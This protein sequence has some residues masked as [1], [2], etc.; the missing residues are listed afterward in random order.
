MN[1]QHTVASSWA[2]NTELLPYAH[3]SDAFDAPAF[4]GATPP[5]SEPIPH[6]HSTSLNSTRPPRHSFLSQGPSARCADAFNYEPNRSVTFSPSAWSPDTT[7][8]SPSQPR[9][10]TSPDSASHG[11]YRDLSGVASDYSHQ[12]TRRAAPARMHRRTSSAQPAFF[13][14]SFTTSSRSY[15]PM[16]N[17]G[18]QTS[19][20]SSH[21]VPTEFPPPS[22][23]SQRM[24]SAPSAEDV[25]QFLHD[26]SEMLGPE[27]IK[28]LPTSMPRTGPS[29]LEFSAAPPAASTSRTSRSRQTYNVA[30]V[31][32]NEEEYRQYRQAEDESFESAHRQA[33][34]SRPPSYSARGMAV[35]VPSFQGYEIYRP[36][37]APPSPQ[38]DLS[39]G[40]V[41]YYSPPPASFEAA[42]GQ[43]SSSYSSF[44]YGR[45]RGSSVDAAIPRTFVSTPSVPQ[46]YG[47]ASYPTPAFIPPPSNQPASYPSPYI[48][49]TATM[50]SPRTTAQSAS[51]RKEVKSPRT[52]TAKNKK[53]AAVVSFINFSPSD[54][55]ALLSGV[56]PSGSS[57]K[58]QRNSTEDQSGPDE[59]PSKRK[60]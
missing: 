6:I 28:I 14:S 32:L 25:N 45:R 2:S 1:S 51:P 3:S 21:S 47:Y 40:F 9:H 16:E 38:V 27:T 26:M 43:L 10:A 44:H 19:T 50:S 4:D 18:S 24:Q 8:P 54:S 52:P 59:S 35:P 5:H 13:S 56:A 34:A 60:A 39:A 48:P 30:G 58:R 23:I 31:L 49:A 22:P 20:T 15:T 29:E 12:Q 11:S 37:S 55:K 53:P 42:P 33:Q 57:K 36:R 7:F 46:P 41:P 17:F